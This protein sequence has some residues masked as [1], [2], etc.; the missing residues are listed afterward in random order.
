MGEQLCQPLSGGQQAP[1]SPPGHGLHPDPR[2]PAQNTVRYVGL[3]APAA[4]CTAAPFE[5]ARATA[6]S[7]SA[8][9]SQNN[10]VLPAA[11]TPAGSSRLHWCRPRCRPPSHARALERKSEKQ[12]L[13]PPS[14]AC[15]ISV[16][17]L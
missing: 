9:Q 13:F 7:V 6:V 17:E 1:H 2:V 4:L 8:K 16:F 15:R 5:T 11:G 3:E 14:T 12:S 10:E